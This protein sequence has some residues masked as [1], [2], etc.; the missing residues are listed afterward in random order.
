MRR[1]WLTAVEIDYNDIPA[2]ALLKKELT[3]EPVIGEVVI[4][5]ESEDQT[6]SLRSILSIEDT[7]DGNFWILTLT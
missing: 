1:S 6:G 4:A 5:Y 3:D 2:T 7:L